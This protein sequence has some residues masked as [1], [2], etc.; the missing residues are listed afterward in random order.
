MSVSSEMCFL[1]ALGEKMVPG[2]VV[3]CVENIVNTFFCEVS[4]FHVFSE[5]VDIQSTF[6]CLFSRFLG[7]LGLLFP[8]FKGLGSRSENQ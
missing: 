6:G 4:L 8:A 7:P 3:G 2:S 5:L 1:V